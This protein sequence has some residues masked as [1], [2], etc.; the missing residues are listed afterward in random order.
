MS[1]TRSHGPERSN[2][3][4]LLKF[5][6]I[7]VIMFGFGYL[8]VPFY[9]QICKAIGLRDIDTLE[10]LARLKALVVERVFPNGVAVLNAEDSMAEWLAGRVKAR[11]AYFSLDPQNER[12]KAHVASGGLAAVMDRHDTLCLYRATLRIPLVH[13]RQV[14]ITFDGKAR[15]NI[16]NALAASLAAFAAG[17]ELDDIRGNVYEFR[18]FKVMIDYCHNAHA[19]A[20]V[21][22]FLRSITRARLI[23]VLNAPGDRR[24]EDFD[25]ITKEAAP[26]FDH[27]ILRD[28]EDL[29]GRE[30]G[31]VT[32]RL[33][34]GLIRHGMPPSEIEE[35]KNE[36]EAVRRG[37]QIARRDDLVVVFA[38]RIPKVAAQIDFERQKESRAQSEG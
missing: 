10:D 1:A 15:F 13:A 35:V 25:A 16:S 38:D 14:P 33:R 4:L 36:P 21:A 28:D 31:E 2:R 18:D 5:S 23:V 12:F 6:L 17:I 32:G 34:E 11:I 3:V 29:R 27:V 9:E 8:M 24:E 30:P 26:H 19:M 22:P 20:L 7:A 37:L